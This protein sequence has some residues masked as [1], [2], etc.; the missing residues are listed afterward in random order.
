MIDIEVECKMGF[1]RTNDSGRLQSEQEFFFVGLII[2]RDGKKERLLGQLN[3]DMNGVV[4]LISKEELDKFHGFV[5]G[6]E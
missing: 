1:A 2:W 6:S 3:V 4:S 5:M